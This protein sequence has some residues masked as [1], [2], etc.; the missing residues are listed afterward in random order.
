MLPPLPYQSDP[1][2]GLLMG[3]IVHLLGLMKADAEEAEEFGL[4][5]DANEL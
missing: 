3:V 5:L 2:H 1:N 4:E